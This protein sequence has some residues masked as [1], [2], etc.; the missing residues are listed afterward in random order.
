M[1]FESLFVF[2]FL[3]S[4][5]AK[6]ECHPT[7]SSH[8]YDPC[9]TYHYLVLLDAVNCL[10]SYNGG[11]HSATGWFLTVQP[12]L[13]PVSLLNSKHNALCCSLGII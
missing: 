10:L 4:R 7:V 9:I 12:A 6:I 8:V 5:V 1:S 3:F 11:M 13:L 2:Y